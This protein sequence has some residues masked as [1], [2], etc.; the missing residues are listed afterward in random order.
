MKTFL[1]LTAI[2]MVIVIFW[3]Q[4]PIISQTVHSILDP[5][6]GGILDWNPSVGMLIIVVVLSLTTSLLQKYLT[7]QETIKELKKDQKEIQKEMKKYKDNPDKLLEFNKKQME[8]MPKLMELTMR[9]AM[10]TIV[11][12]VLFFRWF[13]DYFADSEVVFFGLINAGSSFLFPGWVWFYIIFSI[14][15]SSILRKVLKI[16]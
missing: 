2:S 14:I 13:G 7:D 16:A 10:Y 12:F 4:V 11:F 3:N 15:A 1:I 8:M 6:F 5:T 9:P